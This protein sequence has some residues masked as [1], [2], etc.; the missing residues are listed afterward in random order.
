VRAVYCDFRLLWPE[1][2]TPSERFLVLSDF[3]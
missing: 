3:S 2:Q 1:N